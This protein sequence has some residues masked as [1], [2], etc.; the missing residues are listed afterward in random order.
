[1]ISGRWNQTNEK[2][3]FDIIF[4]LITNEK[5]SVD[6][7]RENSNSGYFFSFSFNWLILSKYYI[8]I[9]KVH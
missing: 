8:F 1:M 7:I 2:R 3:S 6:S 5:V 9:Q 4:A